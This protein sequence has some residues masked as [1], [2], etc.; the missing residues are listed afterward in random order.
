MRRPS[1]EGPHS[2]CCE[3]SGTP[4]LQDVASACARLGILGTARPA[5]QLTK[6]TSKEKRAP[7]PDAEGAR[8]ARE[9]PKSARPAPEEL[10]PKRA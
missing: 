5:T 1:D 4:I 7:P 3:R 6:S 9:N 10:K 8:E 2:S